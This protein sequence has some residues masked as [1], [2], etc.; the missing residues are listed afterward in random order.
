MSE[1]KEVRVHADPSLSPE[2]ERGEMKRKPTRWAVIEAQVNP[3]KTVGPR[4][5]SLGF[6]DWRT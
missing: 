4:R 5:G 6:P 3:S 1:V 2:G